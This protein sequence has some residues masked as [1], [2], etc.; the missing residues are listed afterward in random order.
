M[1]Q[2]SPKQ[3]EIHKLLRDLFQ[4]IEDK[5]NELEFNDIL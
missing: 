5:I 1:T 4:L 3:E 2:L